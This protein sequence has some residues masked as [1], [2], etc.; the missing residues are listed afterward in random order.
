[1]TFLEA[2]K[3]HILVLDG[4]M[5]TMIQNLGL[6]SADFGGESY[7]M[8]SDMLVFSRPH[9]LRDIHLAY[10]EAGAHGVETNTFGASP[11]RLEE[12]DFS[13]LDTLAFEGIPENIHLNTLSSE[14]MAYWMSL[15][16]AAIAK[17]AKEIHAASPDYDGRPLF[18]VGSMGPSNFVLSP[19]EADLHRGSWESIEENFRVQVKGLVDG[20]V[21][22]LLFETQ[23]DMLELKAAVSGAQK[24][25]AE[26]G[27]ALPIICQVT[28]DAHSRMQIFGT[29]IHAVIVTLSGIGIDALG[30]NCSIGPDLMEPTVAKLSRFSPLPLSVLPNAGLPE[31][32]DGKTVFPQSP[33]DLAAHLARFMDTY[34]VNIVGGCCGTT[35]DHI[36]AVAQEAARRKPK[37]RKPEGGVWLAG[38]SKAVLLDSDSRLIRIGERLNVRGS[39]KVRDAVEHDGL[40]DMDAL[41]EVVREQLE[42]LGCEVLDVCM[43]S[44]IV[45]TKTVLPKVIQGICVDFPGALCIDSFDTDALIAAVKAYPGRPLINS[46]SM[47]GHEGMSKAA[48]ICTHTAF[49]NPLYIALAADDKGPAQTRE[50][51]KAIADRL[52]EAVAPHGVG[53]GQLLVDINAFPIGSESVEGM[54]FAL[55]SL[56]SIPL[57]KNAHP[58]IMTT[59]GVSNLT[60]GLAKKPYMRL[61]LTSV[62]LDEGRKKGLDAAIVNPNHYAPVESLDASDYALGRKVVLERDMDAYALLEDIAELKQ[63]R[64][65]ERRSSYEGL[66]P[67]ETLREKIKDGFKKREAGTVRWKGMEIAYQDSIVQ[68][69]VKALE[70]HEPLALI[71]DYLMEAMNVL[72]ERFAAGEASLPHLLKAADVMKAVMGFLEN[73]MAEGAVQDA[74]KATIVM[75]TVYQDV[76]SIGKDLTKTLLENY[77]FRVIDLGVQVPV[78]AFVET[79][80]REKADAIGMSALLVQTANHMISVVKRMDEAGLSIPVFVGGAPVNLRH[81]A[82]VALRGGDDVDNIKPDVFYCQTAMDSVNLM[83]GLI[84]SR[85]DSVIGVNREKLLAAWRSGQEKFIEKS[86]LLASLPRRKVRFETGPA[87]SSFLSETLSPSPSAVNIRKKSLFSLNWKM[88]KGRQD[89]E[90]LYEKWISKA[91]QEGLVKPSGRVAL[92]PAN[93]EGQYILLFDPKN[94]EREVARIFTEMQT[95]SGKKDIFCVADFVRPLSGGV[96]DCVGLQIATAGPLSMEAVDHFKKSGDTESAHLLQGLSD[97][98]AEDLASML[99]ARLAILAG[100]EKGCRYSPGYPGIAIEENRVIHGLLAAKDLGVSLTGAGE[101]HPTSTTAALIVFHKDAG[102]AIPGD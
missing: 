31:N 95:G 45:D 21:D 26:R 1:M 24:A 77:G 14:D 10:F 7:E 76:H 97:R 52:V 47:E 61:V 44:N 63:G 79:A 99:H 73:V 93:S 84:A 82:T 17:E 35:P 74:Y 20:G 13:G 55:E 101:F 23:Q 56:E 40:L 87:V 65:V 92:F 100:A 90:S 33:K 81:A 9:A 94:P 69:A 60:N 64:R 27:V 71:S 36:R 15:K 11:L 30:I 8:L 32:I 18:V 102:Y 91:E 5:G 88:G 75:G 6:T 67:A 4:A 12:F 16:G 2:L 78:D 38:P 25:M 86:V 70:D 62:F 72:G 43:D 66:S 96:R 19:T 48:F 68:D 42:D 22:V 89:G 59:I 98:I 49:H 51:K 53:A 58:G 83:E 85:R 57:I 34:G 80:I 46:I 29:D 39:K 41:E 3:S 37:E 28:V 50:G 54:N